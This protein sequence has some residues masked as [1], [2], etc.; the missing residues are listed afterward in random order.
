MQYKQ[1]TFVFTLWSAQ[2]SFL[3]DN[4]DG[5]AKKDATQMRWQWS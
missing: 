4:I 3:E 5:L 2:L 1:A